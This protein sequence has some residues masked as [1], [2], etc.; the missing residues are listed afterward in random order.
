MDWCV[1]YND[2]M[3]CGNKTIDDLLGGMK[4]GGKCRLTLWSTVKKCVMCY[5]LGG[6]S[7]SR[8]R[9]KMKTDTMRYE[10]W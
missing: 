8:R 10:L 2:S 5:P 7:E 1:E 6:G 3:N 4:H 9:R